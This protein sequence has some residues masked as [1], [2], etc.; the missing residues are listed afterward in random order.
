MTD[1]GGTWADVEGTM[2]VAH[3]GSPSG[4][5]NNADDSAFPREQVFEKD[6]IITTITT[7]K[8]T[9][10]RHKADGSKNRIVKRVKTIKTVRPQNMADIR[11]GWKKFGKGLENEP[12]LTQKE[13]PIPFEL[14]ALDADE[15]KCRDEV[16]KT[17]NLSLDAP[18][19]IPQIRKSALATAPVAAATQ[20]GGTSTSDAVDGGKKTWAAAKKSEA[21]DKK[22]A[23]PAGPKNGP[24]SN[25]TPNEVIRI[26]NLTDEISEVEIRR[27][28]GP[29]NELG[30]IRRVFIAKD[31]KGER[32][33]FAYV[34]YGSV[35]DAQQAVAKMH[36]RKF[37][38][39][40][41]LVD[42][43]TAR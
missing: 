36:K 7:G 43:G 41:L 14:G 11:A 30:D 16:V 28:F 3:S 24:G 42:Y 38:H 8:Q 34:T 9:E 6:G 31:K 25:A 18:I 37:K 10:T 29:G 20:Q 19:K 27:L 4:S 15:K 33:G 1:V 39:A 22:K 40:V 35:R 21:E 12:G 17:M 13:Q 26:S 2:E 32:R 5:P 23:A